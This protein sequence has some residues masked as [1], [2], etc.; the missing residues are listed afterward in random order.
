MPEVLNGEAAFSYCATPITP[1]Y[2][3]DFAKFEITNLEPISAS[4]V[5]IGHYKKP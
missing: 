4:N 3:D 2:K 5:V 1:N